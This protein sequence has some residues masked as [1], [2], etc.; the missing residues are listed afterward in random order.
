MV[1]K[2]GFSYSD[3]KKM[4][5]KERLAFQGFYMQEKKNEKEMLDKAR[6]SPK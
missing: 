1:T 2:V 6:N 4:T 5:R 3:V